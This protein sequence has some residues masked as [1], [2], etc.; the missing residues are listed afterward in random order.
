MSPP[1]L[2]LAIPCVM[3]AAERSGYA[4]FSKLSSN[5]NCMQN[6]KEF[7]TLLDQYIANR[8]ERR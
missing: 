2:K 6:A 3:K 8:Q 7:I 1:H 4:S 5:E